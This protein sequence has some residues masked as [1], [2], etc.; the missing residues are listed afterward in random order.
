[1]AQAACETFEGAG[2]AWGAAASCIIRATA[3]AQSLDTPTVDAM[4][5]AIRRHAD[6]IEYDAFRVPGALLEAWVAERQGDGAAVVDA[7]RRAHELAVRIGFGDHAAFALS[8]LGANALAG[9]N[10]R[11]ADELQQQALATAEGEHATWA[12]AHA[13]VQ[14]ARIASASGDTATAERLYRRVLEWSQLERPREARESLFLA[15]AGSPAAA[16]RLGLEEIAAP[17]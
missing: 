6:A 12:A 5:A 3:A 4:A 1:M 8:G 14:L 2:D 11:E 7:Y 16:A 9:G 15:L 17:T 10:L 13:R